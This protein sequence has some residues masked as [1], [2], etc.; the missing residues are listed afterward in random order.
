MEKEELSKW[1]MAIEIYMFHLNMT[2]EEACDALGIKYIHHNLN[3]EPDYKLQNI[4][5]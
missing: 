4:E 2:R 1:A 5:E 3:N